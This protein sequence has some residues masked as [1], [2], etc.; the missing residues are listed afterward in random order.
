MIRLERISFFRIDVVNSLLQIEESVTARSRDR[1]SNAKNRRNQK[2]TKKQQDFET[3]IN[4]ELSRFEHVK[5]K[6]TVFHNEDVASKI[7]NVLRRADS[8]SER[9]R[10][11]RRERKRER[12]STVA[13]E[14]REIFIPAVEEER[15]RERERER[16]RGR[17]RRDREQAASK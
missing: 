7:T 17:R 11:R 15:G 6:T 14:Q 9:E 2:T 1:S 10:E 4:R 12:E 8:A 3:S 5:A 16:S 13:A